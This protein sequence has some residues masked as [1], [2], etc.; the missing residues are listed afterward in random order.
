MDYLEYALA[1]V[2]QRLWNS[3]GMPLTFCSSILSNHIILD[4]WRQSWTMLSWY[5][6]RTKLM[7]FHEYYN[8]VDNS[9]FSMIGCRYHT[10]DII[11]SK[12]CPGQISCKV[13]LMWPHI[14][15]PRCRLSKLWSQ[16]L[17]S[18]TLF[19]MKNSTLIKVFYLHPDHKAV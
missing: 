3:V 6:C 15:K 13:M 5:I 18:Y 4:E 17:Y 1:Q 9:F 19:W 14:F 12:T 8:N 16:K 2:G 11:L 7:C 10:L